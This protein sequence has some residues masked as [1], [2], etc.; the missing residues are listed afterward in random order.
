MQLLV[1]HVGEDYRRLVLRMVVDKL[2]SS[3]ED[4]PLDLFGDLPE[5]DLMRL[6]LG[7]SAALQVVIQEEG[8]AGA[9]FAVFE[10]RIVDVRIFSIRAIR[11]RLVAGKG[12]IGDRGEQ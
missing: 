8:G 12:V 6:R 11:D 4:S 5:L 2:L 10:P 1:D 9:A 7:A 3:G